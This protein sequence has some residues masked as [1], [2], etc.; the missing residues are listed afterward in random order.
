M[1]SQDSPRNAPKHT[2]MVFHTSVPKVEKIRKVEKFIF[3]IPAGMEIRLRTTGISRQ[4]NTVQLPYLKNHPSAVRISFFE[5][6]RI[7]PH[8]PT[9]LSN[10]LTLTSLPTQ[11][12]ITAPSTEPAVE[13]TITPGTVNIVLVVIKPPNGKTISEGMGGKRF[14]KAITVIIPI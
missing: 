5:T 13:A 11:Y 9:K 7:C 2:R 12:K 8:R 1:T 10:T 4:K 14:S 3:A 6:L